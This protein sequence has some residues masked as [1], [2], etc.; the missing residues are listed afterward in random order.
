[1][2]WARWVSASILGARARHEME[3][4]EGPPEPQST[5]APA[6]APAP[7]IA[8]VAAFDINVP[9]R[10]PRTERGRYVT[11]EGRLLRVR[12]LS[13]EM[14]ESAFQSPKSIL[15]EC[16]TSKCAGKFRYTLPNGVSVA[17]L[18]NE[19]SQPTLMDEICAHC[20]WCKGSYADRVVEK[21]EAQIVDN[22]VKVRL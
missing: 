19:A 10:V 17:D 6:S 13:S 20:V 22:Y 5:L 9:L 4:E 12:G 8:S 3:A 15:L 2:S 21:L 7:A 16:A 14:H 11:K 18:D 1:M